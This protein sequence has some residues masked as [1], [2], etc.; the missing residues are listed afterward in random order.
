MIAVFTCLSGPVEADLYPG[1]HREYLSFG[2]QNVENHYFHLRRLVM[3]TIIINI[4]TDVRFQ[5]LPRVHTKID[6]DI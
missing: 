3:G 1:R 6:H 2:L 4:Q 5:L